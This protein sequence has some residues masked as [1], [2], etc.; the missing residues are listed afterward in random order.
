MLTQKEVLERFGNTTL[1]VHSFMGGDTPLVTFSATLN[2][3]DN[4]AIVVTISVYVDKCDKA[5]KVDEGITL[6]ELFEICHF[7]YLIITENGDYMYNGELVNY[8]AY[9]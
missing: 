4:T 8:D 2:P 1:K 5:V 7:S 9:K 3:D 6:K